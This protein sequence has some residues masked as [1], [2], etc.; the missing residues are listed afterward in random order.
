MPIFAHYLLPLR[1][2]LFEIEEKFCFIS[3][4]IQMDRK[5]ANET[6]TYLVPHTMPDSRVIKVAGQRFEA[7]DVRSQPFSVASEGK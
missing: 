2:A 7:P 6:T 5:I 4:D 1:S 3:A